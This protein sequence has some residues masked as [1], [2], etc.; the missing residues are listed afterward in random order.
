MSCAVDTPTCRPAAFG[1]AITDI[2]LA[3]PTK[4]LQLQ[5]K[6]F[7]G[8]QPHTARVH[9]RAVIL[10]RSIYDTFKRFRELEESPRTYLFSPEDV[11][12][13]RMYTNLMH[14][15]EDAQFVVPMM[16][17]DDCSLGKVLRDETYTDDIITGCS[18]IENASKLQDDLVALL[19]LAKVEAILNSRPLCVL[20]SQ[21]REIDVLTPGHFLLGESL[22]P[23]AEDMWD[24][25]SHPRTR[26]QIIQKST[27]SF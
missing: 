27:R 13:E 24:E 9:G 6:V 19:N 10:T 25:A 14:R 18:S 4:L 1:E 12:C 20:S 5:G 3:L 26:L 2:K 23:L 21:L 16:I 22:V 15:E 17:K 11:L 8:F 7:S